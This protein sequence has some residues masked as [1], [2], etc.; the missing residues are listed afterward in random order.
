[1]STP[2]RRPGAAEKARRQMKA[3]LFGGLGL[4]GIMLVAGLALLFLT[5]GAPGKDGKDAVVLIPPG[6]GVTQI[7]ALLE[8][9]G[10]VRSATAFKAAVQ[11]SGQSG[12][13][14][15][16]EYAIPVGAS[17]GQVIAILVEGKSIQHPITIPEGF[18]TAM[19]MRRLAASQVLSG[20]VPPAPPEGSLLPATY[21][22]VRGTSREEV[23]A[24][25]TRAHDA[26]MAELWPKRAPNLPIRTPAEAVT[27]ASIVEKETGVKD[28]RRK[29][30]GVFINRLRK[31]MKLESDPTI[32]Y[33]ITGGDPIGRRIRL[34]E[35]R[36][37]HPWNT[38]VIPGL[39]PSPIANPGR[40][41]LE[42]V[43]NPEAT[44]ALFFV[45]D[46]TGGH[47]FAATYAEHNANVA[48]WRDV[49]RARGDRTD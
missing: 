3:L 34:S 15:A 39:P 10:G 29:V 12:A 38:Y 44:D 27:L 11:A 37:P 35:I 48:K 8:E 9:E 41:S 46:G 18:T 17:M 14:K 45:A 13:L 28:E 36:M 5:G 20:P 24:R 32:I 42:A 23:L 33:G 19:V 43:L 30:A 1:M 31:G 7:A 16:G 49:Q 47:V 6:S 26:A 40:A 2:D 21:S 4:A 22:V 25:M